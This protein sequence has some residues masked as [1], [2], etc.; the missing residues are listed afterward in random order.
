ML[1]GFKCLSPPTGT[2]VGYIS[3]Q[4]NAQIWETVYADVS[5]KTALIPTQ[6]RKTK[7]S[8]RERGG[9]VSLVCDFTSRS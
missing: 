1:L 2:E 8:E 6:A 9:S 4:T 7:K 5:D 3:T